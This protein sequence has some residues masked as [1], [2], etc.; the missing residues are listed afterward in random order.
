MLLLKKYISV[1]LFMEKS[2]QGYLYM[3]VKH[4]LVQCILYAVQ[5]S[6]VQLLGHVRLFATP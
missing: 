6:S 4:I 2:L 3:L 1:E 5:F